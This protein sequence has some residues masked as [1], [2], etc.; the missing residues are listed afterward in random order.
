MGLLDKRFKGQT[1]AHLEYCEKGPKSLKRNYMDDRKD[2]LQAYWNDNGQK[3]LEGNYKNS[4]R[5]GF[6]TEQSVDGQ[7]KKEGIYKDG[8]E[9]GSVEK[10]EI[11]REGNRVD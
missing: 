11:Y 3:W 8:K 1:R 10:T 4:K 7:K 6:D 5:E 2:E 9:D